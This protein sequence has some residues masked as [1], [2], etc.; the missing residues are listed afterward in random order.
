MT[1]AL[2]PL[3]P[4]QMFFAKLSIMALYHRIFG[5]MRVYAWWI[6][7]I[8]AV[9]LAWVIVTITLQLLT[10]QPMEKFWRPFVPGHCISESLAAIPE[11]TVN[12]GIDFALVILA[13][14]TLPKLQM[15]S[16]SKWNLRIIFGL[17]TM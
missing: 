15:S 6:Y 17:G 4:L 10:C 13:M 8:F 11:E 12:S 9:H 2:L 5:I 14:V 7:G 16:R 3:F 1:F